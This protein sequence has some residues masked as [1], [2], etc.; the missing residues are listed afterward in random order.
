MFQEFCTRL[1][2][3]ASVMYAGWLAAS[4]PA[5]LAVALVPKLWSQK[6]TTAGVV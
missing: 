2:A 1:L 6:G 4:E 3:P 5:P